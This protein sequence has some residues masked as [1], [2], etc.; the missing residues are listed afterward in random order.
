MTNILLRHYIWG[1]I[2]FVLIIGG[3]VS[4]MADM[5]KSNPSMI[6]NTEF[7]NFN[8]SFNQISEI[9][10][11]VNTMGSRI[12]STEPDFTE[13][14]GLNAL[15]KSS[16]DFLKGIRAM[17]NFMDVAFRGL[18]KIFGVPPWIVVLVGLA[19]TV[20]VVFVIFSAIFQRDI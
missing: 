11:N 13:F 9:N 8:K 16:W 20:L 5:S 6:E 10:N 2:A 18:S 3:G 12:N 19:V 15:I 7:S 4:M 14:G 1:A 17:F